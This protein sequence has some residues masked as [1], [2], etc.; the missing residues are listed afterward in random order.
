MTDT[1]GTV[2]V[3]LGRILNGR[4][5]WAKLA[6]IPKSPK[7]SYMIAK[8]MKSVL[9]VN[10]LLIE[11]QRVSYVNQFKTSDEGQQVEV[12]AK[13]SPVKFKQFVETYNEYLATEIDVPRID[14]TMGELIESMSADVD[15]LVLLEIEDFFK[16]SDNAA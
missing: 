2:K 6:K 5:Q 9:E 13:A 7:V 4:E 15:E 8:F 3:T 11:E 10:W 16:A 14:A 12:S 1:S